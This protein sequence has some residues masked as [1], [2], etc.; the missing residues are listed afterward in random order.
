MVEYKNR[1]ELILEISNRSKLFIGEFNSINEKDKDKL[2]DGVDKTPAQMI[3]YQLGW[4]N[5][6]LDWESKEQQGIAVITPTPGYKWN[7]LGGLYE[8]FY[9]K[10][11]AYTLAE[12]CDMFVET[13]NKI[14]QLIN[15]YTDTELFQQ[16]GRKWSSSTPSNWPIWKWIHINTVAPFKSF[17]T[18][19]RKWKKL[20]Q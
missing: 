19:I 5:L 2:I 9:K 20:Q 17:R 1:E 14:I 6:I 8:S 13:E 3:A 18:K 4:M 16:G 11:D 15:T 7:N 12:L 10:Y